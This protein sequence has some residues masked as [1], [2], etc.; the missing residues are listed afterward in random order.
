MLIIR[1]CTSVALK[2]SNRFVFN[3][4]RCFQFNLPLRTLSEKKIDQPNC[5][6]HESNFNSRETSIDNSNEWLWVYLRD[7]IAFTH[8]TEEQ[9]RRVIEIG[10]INDILNSSMSSS[11]L[12]K[13]KRYEKV[14]N[15]YLKLYPMIDGVN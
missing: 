1:I 13:R 7:Q 14:V 4:S 12:Q 10:E 3:N 2:Y 6:S 11:I 15:A 8:L 9:R 5:I